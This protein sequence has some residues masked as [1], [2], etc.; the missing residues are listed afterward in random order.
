MRDDSAEEE[1]RK[2]RRENRDI[3]DNIS[4]GAGLK[5]GAPFYTLAAAKI[6]EISSA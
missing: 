6:N 4:S 2:E 1:N 3:T 5:R